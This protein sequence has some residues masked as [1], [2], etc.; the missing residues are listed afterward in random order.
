MH[1]N[2]LCG[3]FKYMAAWRNTSDTFFESIDLYETGPQADL[4]GDTTAE[5]GPNETCLHAPL[6][7]TLRI[8]LFINGITPKTSTPMSQLYDQFRQADGFLYIRQVE[9]SSLSGLSTSYRYK[10]EIHWQVRC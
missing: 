8:Y 2:M 9:E 6:P 3:E 1:G 5:C 7:Y 10:I 4:G